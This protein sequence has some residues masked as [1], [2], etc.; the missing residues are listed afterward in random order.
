VIVSAV[1][2]ANN[3]NFTLEQWIEF[4][5]RNKVDE[6]SIYQ[7]LSPPL[8]PKSVTKWLARIQRIESAARPKG[9]SA[10][11]WQGKRSRL[12]GRAFESLMQTVIKSVPSFTVWKNV[13]TTTNEIDLLVKVGLTIQVSPIVREWGSHFL[14][15]CKLVNSSINATWVGKLNSVLELHNSEVGILVSAHG[16]PKGKVKTQIHMH[17]FKTPPRIIVCISLAELQEC[18]NGRNFLHLLS[19]RYVEAKTGATGLITQ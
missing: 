19:T 8:P 4:A 7:Y 11:A 3:T 10:Q 2:G 9:V 1:S 14:C 16:A 17:A 15:E 6:D 18:E 12:K 13:T 5:L